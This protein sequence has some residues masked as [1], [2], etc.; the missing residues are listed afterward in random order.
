MTNYYMFVEHNDYEGETWNFYIP[1]SK[2]HRDAIAALIESTDEFDSPYEIGEE[3]YSECDV[4][5]YVDHADVTG[6]MP[7]DI[8]CGPLRQRLIDLFPVINITEDD[9]FY[10]GGCWDAVFD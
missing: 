8:K 5:H 7:S 9:P 10:K 4:N 6:Y 1:M 3:T 2:E